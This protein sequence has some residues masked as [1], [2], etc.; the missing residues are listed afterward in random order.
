[1]LAF[2]P[3]PRNFR[4]LTMNL[5]LNGLG[6]VVARNVAL[7]ERPGTIQFTENSINTGNSR[8]APDDGEITVAM[9]HST[10]T[11]RRTGSRST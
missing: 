10:A 7:G 6:G 9:E 11:S 4:L 1:M 2:E 5:R 3:S 8:V